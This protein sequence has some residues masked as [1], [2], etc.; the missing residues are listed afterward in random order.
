VRDEYG[1]T[2]LKRRQM[3]PI[4]GLDAAPAPIV[5]AEDIVLAKLRRYRPGGETST[6]QWR[7]IVGVLR[8]ESTRLDAA[9]LDRWAAALGLLQLFR[10]AQDESGE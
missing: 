10:R 2:E 4:P 1:A 9:R 5:S 8:S 3:I 6:Q 7:D